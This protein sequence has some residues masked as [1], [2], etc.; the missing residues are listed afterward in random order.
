MMIRPGL[1]PCVCLT[2]DWLR[3]EPFADFTD[4]QC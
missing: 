3:L 2:L 1:N 4:E